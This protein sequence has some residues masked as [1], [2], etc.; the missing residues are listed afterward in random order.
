MSINCAKTNLRN[1]P[2]AF[3]SSDNC[4]ARNSKLFKYSHLMATIFLSTWLRFLQHKITATV[5]K[6][7]NTKCKHNWQKPGPLLQEPH[8]GSRKS[9]CARAQVL[10]KEIML[11][12]GKLAKS[13]CK[14][15]VRYHSQ[16]FRSAIPKGR[17][18][19]EPAILKAVIH[20]RCME[21]VL[22][23]AMTRRLTLTLTLTTIPNRCHS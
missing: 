7:V 11:C 6:T 2:A 15:E 17:H 14:V 21:Y 22:D 4:S 23:I 5:T 9:G 1:L 20:G 3:L 12:W 16:W 13:C 18:S 19:E 8:L 10:L